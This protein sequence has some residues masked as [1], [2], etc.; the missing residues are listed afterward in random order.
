MSLKQGST[1]LI[2]FLCLKCMLSNKR[3]EISFYVFYFQVEWFMQ[4]KEKKYQ[5]FSRS[6]NDPLFK[7]QWYIVST[8]FSK[9]FCLGL[10]FI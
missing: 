8:S 1:V 2:T 4:Q 3:V 7:E 9:Y 6:F 10:L 5:L